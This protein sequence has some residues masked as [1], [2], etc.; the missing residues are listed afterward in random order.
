M[1]CVNKRKVDVKREGTG[2]EEICEGCRA[3]LSFIC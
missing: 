2:K 3:L 1:S